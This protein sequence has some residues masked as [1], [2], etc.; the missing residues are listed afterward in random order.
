MDWQ[1]LIGYALTE[2]FYIAALTVCVF[3][4]L[5]RHSYVLDKL[6]S[7]KAEQD[8]LLGEMTAMLHGQ[9]VVPQ[10]RK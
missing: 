4:L 2:P 5:F 6:K 3:V 10:E 7:E 9:E 1:T 8:K